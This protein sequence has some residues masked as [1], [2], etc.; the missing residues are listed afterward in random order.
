MRLKNLEEGSFWGR[1]DLVKRMKDEEKASGMKKFVKIDDDGNHHGV[2]TSD[3]EKWEELKAQGYK[4]DENYFNEND[5][6]LNE[7]N[8]PANQPITKKDAALYKQA[9]HMVM[10][11]KIDQK[12]SVEMMNIVNKD[13]RDHVKGIGQD[14]TKLSKAAGISR[15]A[16]KPP[17]PL[18]QRSD[19]FKKFGKPNPFAA[20]NVNEDKTDNEKKSAIYNLRMSL[21]SLKDEVNELADLDNE[22]NAS[23]RGDLHDQLATMDKL[24]SDFEAVLGRAYDIVPGDDLGEGKYKNDA[25]RKAVHAS[26]AEKLK[27]EPIQVREAGSP[28]TTTGKH[29]EKMTTDEL[30]TEIA[31][32]DELQDRG[33]TL[34]PK[35]MMRLDS[36][37]SYM[38][39]AEMNEA[40][41]RKADSMMESA[42]WKAKKQ[43]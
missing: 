13:M 9:Q 15:D 38:D 24:T 25:Q 29:P 34:S 2:T 19:N 6:E 16:V 40:I 42:V 4:E 10:K 14:A 23:G 7:F 12:P 37:F 17:A 43:K 33:E 3:K 22:P 21:Q 18:T 28:W 20:E 11:S 39:T 41:K 32:F 27:E 5:K 31:V 26:K 1:D 36:L 8:T 30:W 35:D